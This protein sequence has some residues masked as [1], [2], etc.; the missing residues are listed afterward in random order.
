MKIANSTQETLRP[1]FSVT[2]TA[3]FVE[4]KGGRWETLP[5][6][7]KAGAKEPRP[8][9]SRHRASAASGTTLTSPATV[10]A[11]APVHSAF[12]PMTTQWAINLMDTRIGESQEFACDL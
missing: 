11:R 8:A 12:L 9:A 5:A 2:D 10:S 6:L 4:V 3:R 7:Q 1:F